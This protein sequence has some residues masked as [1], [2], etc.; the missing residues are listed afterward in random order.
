MAYRFRRIG[1]EW[2]RYKVARLGLDID[3]LLT[4]VFRA[5][6][7]RVAAGRVLLF[8]GTNGTI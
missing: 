6:R 4:E 7:C 3:V 5:A 1:H 8:L 2:R